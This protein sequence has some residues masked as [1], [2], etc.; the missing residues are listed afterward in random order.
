MVLKYLY[1]YSVQ[2][3]QAT[4]SCIW[5]IFA[6]VFTHILSRYFLIYFTMHISFMACEKS[7]FIML[8]Y[9]QYYL[10]KLDIIKENILFIII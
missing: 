5:D 8:D 4:C 7:N 10:I 9:F 2:I 1:V 3:Y 6:Y